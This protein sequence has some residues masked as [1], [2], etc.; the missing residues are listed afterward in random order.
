DELYKSGMQAFVRGDTRGALATFRKVQQTSPGYA[1]TWRALGLVY[2]K[3]GDR[4]S[5]RTAYRRYL[6]V[7]PQ[8]PDAAQVR[9]RMEAL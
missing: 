1:P 3:L 8:A 2:E 4:A 6:A 7:A 5:A 9:A